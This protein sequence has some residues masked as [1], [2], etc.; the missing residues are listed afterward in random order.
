MYFF[1]FFC[2]IWR[3]ERSVVLLVAFSFLHMKSAIAE[4]LAKSIFILWQDT[5]NRACY[6]GIDVFHQKLTS[7]K[8]LLVEKAFD[9]IKFS[10]FWVFDQENFRRNISVPLW[11]TIFKWFQCLSFEIF[12]FGGKQSKASDMKNKHLSIA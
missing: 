11:L 12:L 10:I 9:E 6:D 7:S 4:N 1:E 3:R 2:V 5:K 8:T